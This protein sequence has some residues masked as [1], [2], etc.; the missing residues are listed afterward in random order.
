MV[1][2]TEGR[3]THTDQRSFSPCGRRGDHTH[4][5]NVAADIIAKRKIASDGDNNVDRCRSADAGGDYSC[6]L[7]LRFVFH[8]I[9]VSYTHLTLPTIYSV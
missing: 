2:A 7:W 6:S 9:S 4:A 8:L 5:N 3:S 1:D